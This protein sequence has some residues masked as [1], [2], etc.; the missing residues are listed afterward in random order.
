MRTKDECSRK[1]ERRP[2]APHVEQSPTTIEASEGKQ[3]GRAALLLLVKTRSRN[4]F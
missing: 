2:S 1:V 4:V 3:A